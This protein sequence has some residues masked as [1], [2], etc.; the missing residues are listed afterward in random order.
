MLFTLFYPDFVRKQAEVFT[1]DLILHMQV[2]H[3]HV[4]QCSMIQFLILDE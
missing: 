2:C 1:Q 4:F 3:I